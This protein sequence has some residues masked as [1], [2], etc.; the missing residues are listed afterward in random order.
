MHTR[1]N[2]HIVDRREFTSPTH[3][4]HIFYSFSNAKKI[5]TEPKKRVARIFPSFAHFQKCLVVLG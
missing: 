3:Y 4:M 5:S 1:Y 2:L